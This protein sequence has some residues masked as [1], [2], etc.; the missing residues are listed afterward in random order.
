MGSVVLSSTN[1][2]VMVKQGLETPKPVFPVIMDYADLTAKASLET[3]EQ[4]NTVKK[5]RKLASN[6]N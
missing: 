5:G 6:P 2:S 3:R 4:P 1:A